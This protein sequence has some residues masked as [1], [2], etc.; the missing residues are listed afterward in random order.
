MVGSLTLSWCF[1]FAGLAHV[2]TVQGE[3]KRA[4][5]GD[6]VVDQ[7]PVPIPGLPL[8]HT[9]GPT[10]GLGLALSLHIADLAL[11]HLGL[12]LLSDDL[13]DCYDT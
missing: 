12:L 7:G 6:H 9:H 5:V 1:N 3:I 8:I 13:Q 10:L 11:D 4:E 2:P